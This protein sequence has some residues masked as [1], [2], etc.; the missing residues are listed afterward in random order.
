[1]YMPLSFYFPRFLTLRTK[2]FEPTATIMF[3]RECPFQYEAGEMGASVCPRC[4][5]RL[6]T[7]HPVREL[8]AE[9]QACL[10]LARSIDEPSSV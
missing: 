4:R 6:H 1:M 3:C 7:I 5:Q 2:G 8:A 10:K 9:Q